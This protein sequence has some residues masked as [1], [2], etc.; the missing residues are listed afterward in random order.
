MN[1]FPLR[2]RDALSELRMPDE[3]FEHMP[4]TE[5]DDTSSPLDEP[6]DATE[7]SPAN[8]LATALVEHDIADAVRADN[9]PPA[10]PIEMPAPLSQRH[11]ETID[12]MVAHLKTDERRLEKQIMDAKRQLADTQ[13]ARQGYERNSADLRR[14]IAVLI[15][16]ANTKPSAPRQP[17][18]A[19]RS[20]SSARR[21]AVE[22]SN[23][24]TAEITTLKP[25]R[26]RKL[27]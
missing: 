3:V 22:N 8:E 21:G 25:R 4:P 23:S 17:R 16:L 12:R 1:I 5:A 11:L 7:V 26:S 13:L 6:E 9:P 20:P 24:D 14:G 15:R 19:R 10:E 27:H 18:A 2:R